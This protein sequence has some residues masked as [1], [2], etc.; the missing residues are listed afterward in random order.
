M[1]FAPD[2]SVAELLPAEI[3]APT[4]ELATERAR[5]DGQPGSWFLLESGPHAGWWVAESSAAHAGGLTEEVALE[6]VGTVTLPAGSH[7]LR[8]IE[9]GV[10][11]PESTPLIVHGSKELTVDR[12]VVIDGR[13]YD[14]I[15][16]GPAAGHW[17]ETTAAVLPTGAAPHRVGEMSGFAVPTAGVLPAGWATGFR[18]DADGRVVERLPIEVTTDRQVA[19]DQRLTVSGRGLLRVAEGELTGW[20]LAESAVSHLGPV[21][22]LADATQ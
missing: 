9:G 22:A 11:A 21:K 13:A 19:V 6:P 4:P 20:W 2:G 16:A 17:I 14:R 15:A 7:A 18:L 3:A 10:V 1:R 8:L 12:R 5:L